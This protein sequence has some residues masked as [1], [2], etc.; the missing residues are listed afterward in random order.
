MKLSNFYYYLPDELIPL[1]PQND[2]SKDRLMVLHRKTGQIEHRQFS[3][4]VEYFNEGDLLVFNNTKIFPAVLKGK[5]ERTE[6]DIEVFLLRELIPQNHVWD[7]LVTPARKIR[8]GNKLY[9]DNDLVAEVID[10][11][12][13]RGRTIRFLYKG[14]SE[15]LKKL[16]R[17]M[18]NVPLPPFINRDFDPKDLQYVDSPFAKVEGSVAA[19]TAGAH[20]DKI[21][22]KKLELKNVNFAEITLHAGIGNY[23]NIEVEDLVK[24]KPDS[25]RVIITPQTAELINKTL[26]NNKKVCAVGTT[27]LKALETSVTTYNRVDPYDGWTVL[28]IFPPYQIRIANALISN[29]QIPY[30]P[31]LMA[32]CAFGGYKNVMHAYEVA[33]QERYNFGP[34]G[35]AMLIID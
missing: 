25:E 6:A 1:K 35:D 34:F 30:T 2:R 12:T 15:E 31:M 32:V 22:I 11:T 23:S 8:I 17:S 27:V 19:P 21:I 33:V 24:H 7:A 20:F 3:D 29:F 13:S 26:D 9:F 18:G 14:T 4:I 28:F 10:N 16:I 5:K